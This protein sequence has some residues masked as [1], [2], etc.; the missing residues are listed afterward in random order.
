MRG[1]GMLAANDHI[2][3]PTSHWESCV[4]LVEVF[5][6]LMAVSNLGRGSLLQSIQTQMDVFYVPRKGSL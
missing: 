2:P 1:G 5:D 4:R 6:L 3:F